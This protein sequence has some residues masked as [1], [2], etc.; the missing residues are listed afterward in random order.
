MRA[1]DALREV[2]AFLDRACRSGEEAALI[3][4]GH[5]TGALKQ[6]MREYLDAR[7]TSACSAPARATRAAT[8]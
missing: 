8:G 4:H 5:G 6:A 7:P 2:E 3:L 1:D